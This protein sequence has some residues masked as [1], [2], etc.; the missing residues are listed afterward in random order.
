MMKKS[1]WRNKTLKFSNKMEK[2]I[3]MLNSLI[4][5]NKFKANQAKRKSI[6]LIQIK[7]Q[8]KYNKMITL[9]I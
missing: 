9:L 6:N 2:T 8:L 5:K 3:K 4:K 1:S 7:L